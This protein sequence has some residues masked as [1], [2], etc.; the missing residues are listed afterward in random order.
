MTVNILDP[1]SVSDW[2]PARP[3]PQVAIALRTDDDYQATTTATQESLYG[4]RM[5]TFQ[6]L[7]KIARQASQLQ[8]G[9]L[10]RIVAWLSTVPA[11]LP[12]P[13]VA[14]GDDGSISSEWDAEGNSLHI[15]FFNDTNEVYF[16]SPGGDE[17]EGTIDAVDKL[18]N[19]MRTIVRCSQG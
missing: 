1:S 14:I 6:R 2:L 8:P 4:K 18:S 12:E 17:W 11:E 9:A 15:T 10:I 16:F 19:A 13:F 5:A 3:G 7:V